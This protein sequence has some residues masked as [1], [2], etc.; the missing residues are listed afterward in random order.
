MAVCVEVWRWGG[1][2]G[3]MNGGVKGGVREEHDRAGRG[4]GEWR[5]AYP[6]FLYS[7]RAMCRPTAVPSVACCALA[8]AS[9]CDRSGAWVYVLPARVYVLL[10][11]RR[12]VRTQV[13]TAEQTRFSRLRLD[14]LDHLD[15]LSRRQVSAEGRAEHPVNHV[16]QLVLLHARLGGKLNHLEVAVG[17]VV[18]CRGR[19][20]CDGR[21][22]KRVG[23]LRRKS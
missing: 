21:V 9:A 22:Q 1:V 6:F 16:V 13:W 20:S 14:H 5:G 8:A 7:T 17:V 23:E 2:S 3:G 11:G 12:W 4:G 19:E 10:C 15:S 18:G